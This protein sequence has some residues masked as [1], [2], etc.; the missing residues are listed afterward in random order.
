MNKET[1]IDTVNDIRA[2]TKEL[3]KEHIEYKKYIR[4]KSIVDWEEY[5]K[6]FDTKEKITCLT[7]LLNEVRNRPAHTKKDEDYK[8]TSIYSKLEKE[9]LPEEEV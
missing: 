3:V 1:Y 8:R 2:Y 4:S 9:F 7:I 6:Y 5:R